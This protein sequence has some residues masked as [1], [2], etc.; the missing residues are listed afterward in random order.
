MAPENIKQN[1]YS[2]RSDV[3]SYGV[4]LWE[5][6]TSEVPYKEFNEMA[7]AYGIGMGSLTLHIPESCPDAFKDLMKGGQFKMNTSHSIFSS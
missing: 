7:I 1:K 5:L 3:W 2:W 6:L 4:V